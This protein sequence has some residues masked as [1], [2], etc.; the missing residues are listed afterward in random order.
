MFN[1]L[2]KK[3]A[4]KIPGVNYDTN[5]TQGVLYKPKLAKPAEDKTA[6]SIDLSNPEDE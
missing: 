3:L 1:Y 6:E 5:G 4:S 2:G